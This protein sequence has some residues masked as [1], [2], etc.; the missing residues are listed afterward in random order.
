MYAYY[1]RKHWDRSYF[2]LCAWE[3]TSLFCVK[4]EW[5]LIPATGKNSSN[6]LAF[7]DSQTDLFNHLHFKI[8]A[9]TIQFSVIWSVA[10]VCRGK[11]IL[12]AG[13]MGRLPITVPSQLPLIMLSPPLAQIFNKAM[14]ANT[15][16]ATDGKRERASHC[17]I[18]SCIFS[19]AVWF[20]CVREGK[21]V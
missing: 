14:G 9:G 4:S 20:W 18:N 19:I 1:Y 6:V 17:W 12:V 3:K 5:G 2:N 11:G 7:L 8:K 16:E 13:K 10:G 21:W 15:G